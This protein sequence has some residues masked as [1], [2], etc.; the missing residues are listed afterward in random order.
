MNLKNFFNSTIQNGGA[1]YNINTGELNPDKGY[2]VAVPKFHLEIPFSTFNEDSVADYVSKYGFTLTAEH[3]FVGSWIENNTVH[4]DVTE[5]LFD[6][7]IAVTLGLQRNQL[8]VFDAFEGKTISLPTGRQTAGT[9][10]QQRSYI[11]Y[12]VNKLCS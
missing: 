3:T 2:F 4:L 10:T 8:A 7:R 9:L 1:S 12:L 6:K 11:T 5:Q